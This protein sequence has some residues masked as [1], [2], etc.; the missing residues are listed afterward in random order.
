MRQCEV[1][2]KGKYCGLLTESNDRSYIFQYDQEYL[3]CSNVQPVSLTMPLRREP[4]VS[5]H[6]FPF[7][8]NMLSEGVCREIQA[9]YFGLDQ[10]DHFGIMLATCQFDTI[11]A[12]T[13]KPVNI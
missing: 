1:F 9:K 4:Y 2:I 11:G 7:F 13:V 5:K 3:N 8:F 12:V 10:Q 6:L